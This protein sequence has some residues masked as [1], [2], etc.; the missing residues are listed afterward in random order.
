MS[1]AASGLSWYT[2]AMDQ[3]NSIMSQGQQ[4][5]WWTAGAKNS[6]SIGNNSGLTYVGNNPLSKWRQTG[7]GRVQWFGGTR[8]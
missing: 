2:K 1:T 6:S 8:W 3:K 7:V 4:Q 5:N